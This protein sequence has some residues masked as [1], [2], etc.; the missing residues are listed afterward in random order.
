MHAGDQ[1]DP[2]YEE[3][4]D[5]DCENGGVCYFG[6]NP[7]DDDDALLSIPGY[8]SKVKSS[9]HCRCQDGFIGL[10]CEIRF[11][12]CGKDEH[13]CLHGSTC[14]SDS[15]GYTCDC[16]EALGTYAGEYCQSVA[17]EFC[18]PPGKDDPVHFCTN[19]GLCEEEIDGDGEA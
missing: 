16:E 17:T 15:D 6:N 12:K 13:F 3:D 11:E 10:N 18:T 1:V 8:V 19:N 2:N 7:K 5:L 4:C 14:V 9:M